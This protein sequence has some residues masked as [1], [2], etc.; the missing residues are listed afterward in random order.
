MPDDPKSKPTRHGSEAHA[1]KG[2]V[3]TN[4]SRINPRK[5]MMIR[6]IGGF[7]LTSIAAMSK[8]TNLVFWC[9]G[10]R[11][12]WTPSTLTINGDF[13]GK[14]SAKKQQRNEKTEKRHI[15][16]QA[17]FRRAD[18]RGRNNDSHAPGKAQEQSLSRTTQAV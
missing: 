12:E 16:T 14:R 10:N 3:V 2:S 6:I 5:C 18:P 11:V 17:D 7:C 8:V 9:P 15:A 1:A 13:Y 4:T